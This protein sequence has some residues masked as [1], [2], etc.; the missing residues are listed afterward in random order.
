M[1]WALTRG[2][3][4]NTAWVLIQRNEVKFITE[5]TLSKASIKQP[6]LATFTSTG[7]I[8]CLRPKYNLYPLLAVSEKPDEVYWVYRME[9]VFCTKR[10]SICLGDK[11]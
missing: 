9:I 1:G 7:N 5:R 6:S 3:A 4:L 11:T 8:L 2:R 10:D